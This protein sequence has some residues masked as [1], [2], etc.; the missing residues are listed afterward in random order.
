MRWWMRPVASGMQSAFWNDDYD[1][2]PAC[3]VMGKSKCRLGRGGSP[4]LTA[5]LDEV[6]PPLLRLSIQVLEVA[7][8]CP[9]CILIW[10]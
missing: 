5:G 9:L 7:V 8:R 1:C 2:S 3:T 6:A 10:I 4:H